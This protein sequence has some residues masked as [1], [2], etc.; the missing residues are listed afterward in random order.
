M[1][2]FIITDAVEEF[3]DDDAIQR[4][5]DEHPLTWGLALLLVA[6]AIV[7]SLIE[8]GSELTGIQELD[9]LLLLIHGTIFLTAPIASFILAHGNHLAPSLIIAMG[10]SATVMSSPV[11]TDL[12][13]SQN[14]LIPPI[15]SIL[16]LVPFVLV[17]RNKKWQLNPGS[18]RNMWAGLMATS[19][20]MFSGGTLIPALNGFATTNECTNL[21]SAEIC[22]SNYLGWGALAVVA[23]AIGWAWPKGRHIVE[24]LADDMLRAA[25]RI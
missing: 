3:F 4:D 2:E 14:G 17:L 7:L 20:L 12:F 9:M 19:I 11:F 23:M 1:S 5:L 8:P 10:A 25:R 24:E 13:P 16:I 6:P 21:A 18:S 22:A 15:I